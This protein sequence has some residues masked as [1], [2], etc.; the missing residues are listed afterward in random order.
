MNQSKRIDAKSDQNDDNQDDKTGQNEGKFS[1]TPPRK[2]SQRYEPRNVNEE[3]ES[4]S[5]QNDED[6]NEDDVDDDDVDEAS[7]ESFP[8]SD[9]PP[10]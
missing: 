4:D 9:P 1:P 7:K 5:S 10:Y 3:K 8:A 2:P 6:E